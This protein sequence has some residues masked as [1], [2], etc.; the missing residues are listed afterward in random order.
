MA[1]YPPA[2]PTTTAADVLA[3]LRRRGYTLAVE[4]KVVDIQTKVGVLY[5]TVADALLIR[6]P[7]APP[8]YLREAVRAHKPAI[9]AAAAV[10]DP[11]VGWIADLARRYRTGDAHAAERNGRAA[12]YPVTLDVIAANVAAFVGLNPVEDA[13]TLR[14]IIAA[15]IGGGV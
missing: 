5:L 10:A 12:R 15:E 2:A 14:E 11:P 3:E 13:P 9:M 4:T 7:E 8:E 6:G 1:N